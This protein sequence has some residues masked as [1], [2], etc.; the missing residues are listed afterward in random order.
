M[1]PVNTTE[2]FYCQINPNINW[3]RTEGS[4]FSSEIKGAPAENQVCVWYLWALVLKSTPVGGVKIW[5]GGMIFCVNADGKKY[6]QII[7]TN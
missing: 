7:K 4:S 6:K 2:P 5:Y 1:A 3:L